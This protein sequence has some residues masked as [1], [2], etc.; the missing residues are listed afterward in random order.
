MDLPAA[1]LPSHHRQAVGK[2]DVQ[3]CNQRKVQNGQL[4]EQV[5]DAAE[6]CII[7]LEVGPSSGYLQQRESGRGVAFEMNGSVLL[8]GRKP[9]KS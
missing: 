5:L 7:L 8:R 2:A 6:K 3:P 1:G 9:C 4:P